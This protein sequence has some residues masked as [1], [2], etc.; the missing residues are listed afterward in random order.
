[1]SNKVSEKELNVEK[2]IVELDKLTDALDDEQIKARQEQ[3]REYIFPDGNAE[4]DIPKALPLIV[5]CLK[6]ENHLLQQ[7]GSFFTAAIILNS[8]GKEEQK[9]NVEILITAQV[10]PIL[11]NLLS[12]PN[13]EV[14]EK[15]LCS[16]SL[17]SFYFPKQ[18]VSCQCLPLVSKLLK[19]RHDRV[20]WGAAQ[21]IMNI[22]NELQNVVRI[23][24]AGCIEPFV[25]LL[26]SN[27]VDICGT[28]IGAL[29]NIVW[30]KSKWWKIV[31]DH[32]ILDRLKNLFNPENQEIN[33]LA[34]LFIRNITHHGYIDIAVDEGF[35]DLILD[36]ISNGSTTEI[37][38]ESIG[39]IKNIFEAKHL[40]ASILVDEH[41]LVSLLLNIDDPSNRNMDF[42]E[43]AL[44]AL[45]NI[46]QLCEENLCEEYLVR[47]KIY[48]C[49]G[50][51]KIE[52]LLE[53]ILQKNPKEKDIKQNIQIQSL[54][55]EINNFIKCAAE[56]DGEEYCPKTKTSLITKNNSVRRSERIKKS[57]L[58][59]PADSLQSESLAGNIIDVPSVSQSH[60]SSNF[61]AAND[62]ANDLLQNE[63]TIKSEA[64][65]QELYND[66]DEPSEIQLPVNPNTA[67]V[68]TPSNQIDTVLSRNLALDVLSTSHSLVSPVIAA[69]NN[70]IPIT[71]RKRRLINRV[72]MDGNKRIK[73]E[74]E[75]AVY[76]EMQNNLNEPSERQTAVNT[77][78]VGVDTSIKSE[79]GDQDYSTPFDENVQLKRELPSNNPSASG[80]PTQS[81]LPVLDNSD[82][83]SRVSAS[84][85][86]FIPEG[87]T[88]NDIKDYSI[89]NSA[90]PVIEILCPPSTMNVAP[91]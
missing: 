36:Q 44:S 60:V 35:I 2:I 30:D 85:E 43:T 34:T 77:V 39:V 66:F 10:V 88:D 22:S 6:S 82:H 11:V 75:D 91:R 54:L 63:D 71:R 19:S 74:T 72:E 57:V 80:S 12:S 61:T 40:F 65:D 70:Q 52:N 33:Y 84:F 28:A 58:S 48:E 50:L 32:G 62:A 15:S 81:N 76:G 90:S 83:L 45:T 55:E 24:K 41:Q 18:I 37:K 89:K 26:G 68:D 17:I 69:T 23:V 51:R 5:E 25:K 31:L 3:L 79:P 42:V 53:K 87:L 20:C 73:V 38:I 16:L 29:V 1:M 67:A 8:N 9:K 46:I 78:T 21:L 56:S 64:V 13:Y 86:H 27:D 4:M 14:I 47:Q 59:P 7:I 49:G